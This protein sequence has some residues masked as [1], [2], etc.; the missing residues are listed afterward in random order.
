MEGS[1]YQKFYISWKGA[2]FQGPNSGFLLAGTWSIPLSGT[3]GF[4]SCLEAG[5]NDTG[6]SL[7]QDPIPL[8]LLSWVPLKPELILNPDDENG[9]LM[10]S[11]VQAGEVLARGILGPVRLGSVDLRR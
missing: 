9:T 4:G 6:A 8:I 1:P 11:G 10:L 7:R 3:R 5:G 2:R